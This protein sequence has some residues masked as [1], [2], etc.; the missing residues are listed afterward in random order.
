MGLNRRVLAAAALLL[1][2]PALAH[3]QEGSVAAGLN[4]GTPGVGASVHVQASESLV[5]RG[6]VDWLRFSHDKNY[7]GV[8]YDGRLKSTTAGVFADWHPGGGGFL[9]SGGAYLGSRKLDID[10][11]PTGNVNIGG[12]D[13]TPA[14]IGRIAGAAKM[15]KVQPFAGLGYDNTFVGSGWGVRAMA[16]VAFSR[17][18]DVSLTASG[19]TLSQ[20][21]NFQARLEQEEDEVRDDAKGFRFFPVLQIGFTRRF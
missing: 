17:K 1:G 15:S 14:Q 11:Q 12:Q 21:A 4:L 20:D 7:S 13:F 3:A 9:V 8:D 18:P 6:D 5:L 2:L 19:G 16:G 10:A